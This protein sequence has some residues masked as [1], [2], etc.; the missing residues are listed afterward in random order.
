MHTEEQ[1]VKILAV[2][3]NANN[4]LALEAIL[5]SP[6]RRIV[7]ASSGVEALRYLL[8]DDAAVIL[9]DV[10]MP[11]MDGLETAELIRGR[12]RSRD[13]PIIFVTADASGAAHLSRGYSLGAVDYIL[14]PVDPEIL[15]SKVAVFVDLY[16]KT[17]EIERQ[18]ELLR[19]KNR[20]IENANLARLGALVEL[21]Q[22]LSAERDPARLLAKFCRR[23]RTIVGAERTGVRIIGGGHDGLRYSVTCD[24]SDAERDDFGATH[25][26]GGA[27]AETEHLLER[28]LAEGRPLRSNSFEKINGKIA[29]CFLVAPI[30]TPA[31]T[32]GWMYFVGKNPD[33]EFSEADERLVGTLAAQVAVTYQNA[34]L[35]TEARHLADDLRLEVAER[36][37][38]Q[39]EVARLLAGEQTARRES[40][41]ANRTKDE[42]LA[43]LSHELRTPLTAILGWTHLLLGGNLD[44]AS[45]ARALEI[46]QRNAKS[47]SQLIDDLLDVSRIVTG[48]LRIDPHP[49]E[50]ASVI[51]TAIESVRPAADSN[52]ISIVATIE[53]DA[54][55]V[56]GDAGRLQQVVWNL[57]TNA[58]KFTPKGGRV[59]V[60][61]ARAKDRTRLTIVDSGPGISADFLPYIFD[62]FRQEDGSRTRTHGGLGLGLAI[63][64]HLVELHGGAVSAESGGDGLGSTFAVELPLRSDPASAEVSDHNPVDPD[65]I[66]TQPLDGLQVLVVEDEQDTRDLISAVLSGGGAEVRTSAS[67]AE[68]LHTLAAWRPDVLVSDIGMP[69]EDG[70][71]LIRKVQERSNGAW[72]PSLALTA[73]ASLDDRARA[74]AAGFHTHMAKP[75]EPAELV[76]A[77]A[78]LAKRAV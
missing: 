48:K 75:I 34:V 55:H 66:E 26:G 22:E 28:A 52:E 54:G 63:V 7:R 15:K 73:Y 29:G 46:V 71:A 33:A 72:L 18:A 19:E 36:R 62:R 37:A 27:P 39:E 74:I 25:D 70:Y 4:L 23:A 16:R 53:P 1:L 64:R 50:F 51:E 17:R 20:E 59:T 6:D 32:Y 56:T 2:D 77:V 40:E 43:V 9:L 78:E 13:I 57:L 8:E 21:G 44:P 47:Q 68:A 42:F 38:A 58:V 67:V 45:S 41:D 65:T 61:L 3:D 60:S 5:E 49:V 10:Y 14:K 76:I 12:E 31:Q 69:G 30:S 35:Y 24:G 11:G